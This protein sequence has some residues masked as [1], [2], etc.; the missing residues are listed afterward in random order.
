MEPGFVRFSLDLT[1]LDAYGIVSMKFKIN[2]L[3][4]ELA[5]E[6]IKW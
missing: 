6:P 3:A 4:Y 5:K 1:R 2:D